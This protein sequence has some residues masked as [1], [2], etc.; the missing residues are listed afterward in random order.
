MFGILVFCIQARAPH[1]LTMFF[2]RPRKLFRS[3]A[4]AMAALV[5][6]ASS[7]NAALLS[8]MSEENAMANNSTTVASPAPRTSNCHE[9]AMLQTTGHHLDS[10]LSQNN[11]STSNDTAMPCCKGKCQ[12]CAITITGIACNNFVTAVLT[13]THQF[14]IARANLADAHAA[15][16]YRPP[17]LA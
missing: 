14:T 3:L 6:I 8:L 5:F 4:V 17:N 11:D 2:T 10:S 15:N 9:S 13:P 1:K 12:L 7:A 16:L